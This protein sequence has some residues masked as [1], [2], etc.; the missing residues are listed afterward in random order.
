VQQPW[1]DAAALREYLE[2]ATPDEAEALEADFAGCDG[3]AYANGTE[4]YRDNPQLA[5]ITDDQRDA[6][7]SGVATVEQYFDDHEAD[8]EAASSED[9][10]ALARLSALGLRSWEDEAFY[11]YTDTTASYEA[12]DSAMA[13]VFE[14][15]HDRFH[16]GVKTMIWAHNWH[17]ARD[18]ADM[19][20]YLFGVHNMGSHLATDLGD[21]YFPIALIGYDVSINWPGVQQ[22]PIPPPT[23]D[24][25]V[26]VMLHGLERPYLLVDL[27]FPGAAAPFL[28]PGATYTFGGEAEDLVPAEQYGG[29]V[30]L[31]SSPAM[32]ALWW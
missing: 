28:T 1:D 5:T 14:T 4:Y 11:Y 25:A 20:G 32:D 27:A 18:A 12:R 3:A 21:D 15:I 10:L 23:Q 19:T 7:L 29:I 26:E 24:N 2:T 16:A 30:Y 17:I 22:G 9:A 6:C 31:D 8:L 13:Q